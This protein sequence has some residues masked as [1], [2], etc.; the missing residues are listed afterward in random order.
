MKLRRSYTYVE[1]IP[2]EV[3]YQVGLSSLDSIAILLKQ[4]EHLSLGLANNCLNRPD[5]AQ[6]LDLIDVKN[7]VKA[8][9]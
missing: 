8:Q 4:E 3:E 7:G 6:G 1:G 9:S 2:I 5:T